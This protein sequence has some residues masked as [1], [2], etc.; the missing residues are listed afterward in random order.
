MGIPAV[1]FSAPEP[2]V[3]FVPPPSRV[4]VD[5]AVEG[6]TPAFIMNC[7][8]RRLTKMP[9]S[10]PTGKPDAVGPTACGSS[11]A[12]TPCRLNGSSAGTASPPKR[13][14]STSPRLII[15]LLVFDQRGDVGLRLRGWAT[16][17]PRLGPTTKISS[18]PD[19]S[20]PP[21][22]WHSLPRT[23][24]SSRR[25]SSTPSSR[26]PASTGRRGDG[27]HDSPVCGGVAAVGGGLPGPD[28][29]AGGAAPGPATTTTATIP[30][31]PP[32]TFP[33]GT[34]R[35]TPTTRSGGAT[36]NGGSSRPTSSSALRR[37]WRGCGLNTPRRRCIRWSPSARWCHDAPGRQPEPSTP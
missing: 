32:K 31:R 9:R 26:A 33:A 6:S 30:D 12:S 24:S 5:R 13:S 2:N 25:R 10:G 27:D 17:W 21:R 3:E 8:G 36:G 4:P 15:Q 22:H 35:S 28:L 19:A 16:S 7:I 11:S 18:R 20:T 14:T 37:C 29:A 23:S 34:S 1:D